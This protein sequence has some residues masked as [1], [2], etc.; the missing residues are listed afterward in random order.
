MNANAW[1][2]YFKWGL[3]ALE[4]TP[5][6]VKFPCTCKS[7]LSLDRGSYNRSLWRYQQH[8]LTQFRSCNL[9]F[10]SGCWGVTTAPSRTRAKT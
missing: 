3:Y 5:A 1:S 4:V 10:L 7:S 2:R 9:S 6:A 8:V